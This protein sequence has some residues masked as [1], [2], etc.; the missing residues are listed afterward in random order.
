MSARKLLVLTGVVLALFAFIYFFE[1]KAPTTSEREEKG[2][3]H[4]DLPEDRVE[5]I[6]LE[7]GGQTVELAKSGDSWKLVQPEPYPADSIAVS[8]LSSGLAD[9]KK[10]SGESEVEGK[11][12]DYG[13]ARPL[14]KATFF[15]S[16]PEKPGRRK[17]S[18]TLEF[19]LEIP[20]TDVT[21]ARVAGKGQ[22]LF[23]PSSLAASVRKGADDFKSKEVFGGS[24]LDVTGVAVERGRGRLVLAK[25][26]GVWWL[27]EPIS[28]LADGAVADRLAGD[29][30]ALRV[31]E[32]V[33]RAQAADGAALG[34]SP[35]VFR[36]TITDAKG[37]K[38]VLDIGSTRSDGNSVYASRLGQVFTVASSL[39]EELSKEAV[40]FRDKLLLRFDR[41]QAN[42][43]EATIAGKR[44][45]FARNQAGWSFGGR[46]LLASAADDLVSA[47][48][49]LESKSFS[50]DAQAKALG[51]RQPDSE[52]EVRLTGGAD[53]K[54]K[55]YPSRGEFTATVSR[56][57]GAF[58]LAPE[59]VGR[60][61]EAFQK[62]A[63][64]PSSA[65]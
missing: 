26:G 24:S 53:W 48:L 33:P 35:P 44:Y 41:G 36:V 19:G 43:I 61:K 10:P 15:W 27:E 29:F 40:A 56:R 62:A 25:K 17:S 22:I 65:G 18:R 52:F 57:P 11:P 39:V 58:L 46:A 1:R 3:L 2:E 6:R 31:T 5:R 38:S 23:V 55:L 50:D 14:A 42:A 13:L 7:H 8:E 60:V 20:G 30:S 37:G 54:V 12:E 64:A 21:A 16:D 28:D 49:D 4:W 47:L 34:L 32:F 45:A 9:L 63:A 51:P 59:G